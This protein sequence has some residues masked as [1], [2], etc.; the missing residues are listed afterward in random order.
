MFKFIKQIFV[1]TIMFFAS[2]SNV[3]PLGCV[4]MK[5]QECKVR[6]EILNV[7]RKEPIFYACSIKTSKCCGSCNNVNDPYTKLCV[8]DV[9]KNINVKVFNL[10]SWTN[11]TRYIKW[12]ETF[13]CL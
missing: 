5:N 4:S 13:K 11:Q 8:P 6:P 3:N 7:N 12:H 2:P 1:S 9:I 10:I